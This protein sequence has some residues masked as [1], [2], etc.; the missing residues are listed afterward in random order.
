MRRIALA[1]GP[2][3]L[4][5]SIAWPYYG[6]QGLRTIGPL[7]GLVGTALV[8][9]AAGLQ[10]RWLA[11]LGLV[12]TGAAVALLAWRLSTP[13]TVPPLFRP[14][15]G[16]A[17]ST[18][19]LVIGLVGAILCA[20]AAAATLVWLTPNRERAAGLRPEPSAWLTRVSADQRTA[21]V[22]AWRATWSSRLL[23][24][25][26][27]VLAVLQSAPQTVSVGAS[28]ARPFGHLGTLLSAPAAAWDAGNYLTLA[29]YGYGV[30]RYLDAY[31][32]AY[33]TLVRFGAWSDKAALVTAILVSLAALLGALYF[34]YR[35]VAL[36]C[37]PATARLTVLLMAFFP[38]SLF[39]SA[40]YTES[41]FLLLTVAAFY[42]GRRGWW[43]RA[44]IAG[45]LAAATRPTGVLVFFPLLVLYLF[46]PRG[47][48]L[49][50]GPE[51]ARR[52][53]RFAP[54]YRLRRDAVYLLL[55]PLGL[56]TVLAYHGFHGDWL[57]PLHAERNFWHLS[58]GPLL[59]V[60]EGTRDFVRSVLQIVGGA[61]SH[62]L[63]SQPS[64]QL[65][66]PARLSVENIVDFAFLSFGS[67]A[68]IGA[69]RRLPAAYGLYAVLT[70]LFVTSSVSHY[71]P[72]VSF[73][74]Y[75]MVAFPIQIWL[76]L[77]AQKRPGRRTLALALSAGLLALFA[78][79]FA[80]WQ[81][82]A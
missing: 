4:A 27:G 57:A 77:W 2:A 72:L 3:L 35:L 24:W 82:V 62:Y 17:R 39:F 44:G 7:L 54:R 73:P 61:T 31:F 81:W 30:G 40:V 80:S 47:E 76:A 43:A 71:Q 8:W 51:A 34:L 29:R 66:T 15:F 75:L 56:G 63:P 16:Q 41:L 26:A 9:T 28:L 52:R 46:G 55:V 60:I 58:T 12:M 22:A 67:V 33:P 18:A 48:E 74:R 25:V 78:S 49:E 14:L 19:G 42:A 20:L 5:L 38:M 68:T 59:G 36:E 11:A 64:N 65:L 79:E 10:K 69:F 21:L 1:V 70:I 45:A 13:M 32:P 6:W 50:A 53:S 23:V 37:G